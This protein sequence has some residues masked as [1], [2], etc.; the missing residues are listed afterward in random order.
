M[1][2]SG[3]QPSQQP[4]TTTA[5]AA[6]WLQ[7]LNSSSASPA[8]PSSLIP[9]T[10]ESKT[11]LAGSASQHPAVA[12]VLEGLAVIPGMQLVMQCTQGP[13]YARIL[14]QADLGLPLGPQQVCCD[15]SLLACGCSH[16]YECPH[17]YELGC[18]IP[19]KL[20]PC[21]PQSLAFDMCLAPGCSGLA[22]H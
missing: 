13:A 15:S 17:M 21:A 10:I 8:S 12:E 2:Y 6:A 3:S 9:L 7:D 19:N 4:P 1:L 5:W 11:K 18:I 14:A 16:V 20:F 22:S